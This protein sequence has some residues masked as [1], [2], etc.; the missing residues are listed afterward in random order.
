MLKECSIREIFASIVLVH[1]R[2]IRCIQHVLPY[3]FDI[4]AWF[5]RSNCMTSPISHGDR[6]GAESFQKAVLDGRA[7]LYAIW[8]IIADTNEFRALSVG[9][10]LPSVLINNGLGNSQRFLNGMT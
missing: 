6:A 9:T 3:C 4:I 2:N 8:T 10:L 5:L 7:D 1:V